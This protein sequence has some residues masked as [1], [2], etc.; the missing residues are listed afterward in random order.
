MEVQAEIPRQ[1]DTMENEKIDLAE[2]TLVIEKKAAQLVRKLS[3][4]QSQQSLTSPSQKYSTIASRLYTPTKVGSRNCLKSLI[5]EF[6]FSS[7]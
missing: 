6:I 2:L 3:T 1:C 7:I 5:R 4:S